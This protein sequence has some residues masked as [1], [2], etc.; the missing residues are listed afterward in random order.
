M[1]S[2]KSK[3]FDMF[4]SILKKL[5]GGISNHPEDKGGLTNLGVTQSVYDAY[6]KSIK[7]PLQTVE[8]ISANEVNSIYK[9]GYFNP[10]VW[11]ENSRCHY[12]IFDIAV[13]SG[14]SSAKRCLR[15]I[16][17]GVSDN[18]LKPSAPALTLNL[19]KIIEWRKSF[20][21]N[22]VDKN[23]KQSVFLKGWNNRVTRIGLLTANWE[24]E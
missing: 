11:C 19:D 5:E 15:D 8:L 16:L 22:I 2:D 6:R 1:T 12:H 24:E 20:Y 7:Q 23:K 4:M 17:P 14:I 9:S 13:N 10:L 18:A 3:R 21:Q